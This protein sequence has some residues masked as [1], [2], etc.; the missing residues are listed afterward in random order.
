MGRNV[1]CSY[2]DALSLRNLMK[3]CLSESSVVEKNEPPF[4]CAAVSS[5]GAAAAAQEHEL[6]MLMPPPQMKVKS[7]RGGMRS[8]PAAFGRT[9]IISG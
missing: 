2:D 8:A 3:G 9:I 5:E 6:Q 7:N 1:V 4:A